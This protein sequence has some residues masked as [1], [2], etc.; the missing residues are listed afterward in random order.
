M[1]VDLLH[2]RKSMGLL[3]YLPDVQNVRMSL[4]L[5]A[6]VV[7]RRIKPYDFGLTRRRHGGSYSEDK[8]ARKG[9]T[10]DGKVDATSGSQQ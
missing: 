6:V 5:H 9:R 8:V 4:S 1:R 2:R 7:L 10:F 3:Q